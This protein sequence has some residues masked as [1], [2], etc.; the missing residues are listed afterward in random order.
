MLKSK[1]FIA[2]PPG[3]TIK[4]QLIDRKMS[5]KEFAIRMDMSE[6]H[7]SR[8]INGEVILTTDMALRLEMVLGLPAHF[9]S[10]LENIYREKLA[11]VEAENS[12]TEDM[13]IAKKFPYNE[14]AQFKWVPEENKLENKVVNLRKY[15]EVVKLS[16]LEDERLSKIKFSQFDESEK[17]NYAILAW[18]QKAK[19]EA[20]KMVIEPI[21]I[22]RLRKNLIE[23][24]NMT[25]LEPN[26]FCFKLSKMLGK[27]GIALVYLPSISQ[28][29][30]HGATFY[31]GSKIVLGLTISG[32]DANDFWFSLFHELGHIVLGHLNNSHENDE[33]E[34]DSFARDTLIPLNQW[35]DF[36]KQKQYTKDDIISFAQKEDINSGIVLDRLQKEHYVPLKSFN[37]LKRVYE[38]SE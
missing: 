11:K 23:I 26:E 6:K 12:L 32:K 18:T 16:L 14:M 19:L 22:D 34:A 36:I 20:R 38:L 27:C 25:L 29:Y 13:E 37:E 3:E 21:N 17:E 9:W 1:T 30:L 7:I 8:L 33:I 35:Q 4:E 15:F 5:Q 24:R 31:D 28:S 10:N 2:T